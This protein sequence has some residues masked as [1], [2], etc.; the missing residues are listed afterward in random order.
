MESLQS[1]RELSMANC[2][3]FVWPEEF[4]NFSSLEYLDVSQN[5]FTG[6]LGPWFSSMKKIRVLNAS[7]T[8]SASMI[9]N[10]SDI[11]NVESLEVLNLSFTRNLDEIPQQ[12]YLSNIMRLPNLIVV[13]V[14]G[15]NITDISPLADINMHETLEVLYISDEL[16]GFS[17]ISTLLSNF[18]CTG[19]DRVTCERVQF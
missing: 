5:F 15:M 9:L 14:D 3:V 13:D 4:W 6:L 10:I 19:Q 8:E 2:D 7:D 18:N 16:H 17:N 12:D 1:L 11:W